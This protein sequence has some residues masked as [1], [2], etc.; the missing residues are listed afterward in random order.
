[1]GE[2]MKKITITTILG[3]ALIFGGIVGGVI[4]AEDRY[5]KCI[6]LAQVK[7]TVQEIR[8]EIYAKDL[9]RRMWDLERFYG[10]QKARNLRE[11]RELE[12]ERERILRKL[13]K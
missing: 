3:G 2:T 8:L 4:T 10:P 6:E 5:A 13:Q 1:M 12:A 9:R 11:Y 7:Q